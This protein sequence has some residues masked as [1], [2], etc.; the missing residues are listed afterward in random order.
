MANLYYPQLTSG[1]LAQYPI[2][3]TR[4][5]RTVKNILPD[6][7]LFVS[8]DPG[9]SHLLWNLSYSGLSGS[10][11]QALQDHFAACNGPFHAFTFID[12][13]DNM[14]RWSSDLSDAIWQTS[15]LVN[16]RANAADPF[17]GANAFTITNN[18]QAN[19]VFC[20]TVSAPAG[21]QYCFSVY[22]ASYQAAT[23]IMLRNGSSAVQPMTA[24]VSSTWQ[25]LVS[26][27]R[28]IDPGTAFT[29]G[30]SL[31]PGQQLLVYG[32]QLEAQV[33]PSSYRPTAQTSSVY[34]NSHW[35]VEQ[36]PIAATAPDLFSTAFT[37]ETTA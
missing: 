15:S 23:V 30:L 5:F 19:Q 10:D 9:Y 28:L 13:T 36:L 18:S 16:I 33:S 7:S 24:G 8:A 11:V 21:Y 26:S 1:A 17:G 34:Q 14:L 2:T 22:L 37:I 31:L 27:G 6:G 4:L 35:S 29:V 25:R 12:P 32:P 3:K 20:Q